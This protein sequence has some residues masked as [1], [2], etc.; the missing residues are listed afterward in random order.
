MAERVPPGR[1]GRLFLRG[2]LD[3]ARRSVD[4]LD[5][6]RQLLRREIDAMAER[7][8]EARRRWSEASVDADAWGQRVAVLGGFSGVAAAA[9][10][11]AG[12][13]TVEVGWVNTMGVR[14][15]GA[16]HCELPE[17]APLAMASTLATACAL[18]AYRRALTAAADLAVAEDAMS[19]LGEELV[20]TDHRLRAIE[21]VR[22]PA[23][24][25]ALTRVEFQLDEVE[26]AERVTARWSS[27]RTPTPGRSSVG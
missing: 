21:K 9:A 15:P 11:I 5:R 20:A 6:K 26:R 14:H 18:D 16:A 4:L 2:R 12:A 24:D 23:L 22:V 3:S 27:R 25:T 1:A 17:L 10:S 13:A 8:D 19:R 7:R